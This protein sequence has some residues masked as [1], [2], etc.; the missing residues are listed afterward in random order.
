MLQFL[1]MKRIS[2]INIVL[3]SCLVK[4]FHTFITKKLQA[5]I[6]DKHVTLLYYQGSWKKRVKEGECSSRLTY[7]ICNSNLY[8]MQFCKQHKF[9]PTQIFPRF[10]FSSKNLEIKPTHKLKL[11][12]LPIHADFFFLRSYQE[13]FYQTPTSIS[14]S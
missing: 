11:S 6:L 13:H 14:N 2:T 8:K 1:R 7:R 4:L 12:T 9:H 10:N 3:G 5:I